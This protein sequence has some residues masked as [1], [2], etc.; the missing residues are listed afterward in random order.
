MRKS[1]E[2]LPA[3]LPLTCRDGDRYNS[4]ALRTEKG[5]HRKLEGAKYDRQWR[6]T[7]NVQIEVH[8]VVVL[9]SKKLEMKHA[10]MRKVDILQ[11]AKAK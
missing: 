2:A 7:I 3:P 8:V 11:Q 4:S 6:C 5:T 9:G 1:A 10:I